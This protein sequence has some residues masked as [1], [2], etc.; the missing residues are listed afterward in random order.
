MSPSILDESPP[1]EAILAAADR[2]YYERGIQSVGMDELRTA[3]GVSLK[4][5]Y[6]EFPSKEAVIVAVLHGRHE[7][8]TIGVSARVAAADGPRGKLLA[9]YDFLF[10]WFSEDSFRG[11]G[12]INAFGELGSSHPAVALLAREHKDSFQRFLAHLAGEAG[13][14]AELAAQLAILAEGAQTTAAIAGSPE[15]ALHARRAAEVLI[16]AETRAFAA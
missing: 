6:A 7:Q 3:A 11:C 12:F 16:D 5:L 14:G 8:W 2:L 4:R 13:G 1:R 10:D 15:A 9:I